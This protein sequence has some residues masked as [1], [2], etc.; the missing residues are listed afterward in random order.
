MT[1]E[2]SAW[3]TVENVDCIPSPALLIYPDRVEENIRRMIRIAGGVNRLRPHV[4]THKLA[5]IVRMQMSHGIT[6]FKCATIAEMEMVASCGAADVLLAFQP[7]G[8]N[9]RR[10]LQLSQVFPETNLC[11]VVDDAEAIRQLSETFCLAGKTIEVLLDIDCGMHRTGVLPG[12]TA[13][14][15]YRLIDSSIGLKAGGLHVYDGHLHQSDP[16]ERKSACDVAYAPVQDLRRQLEASGLSVPRIVAGGTPTF[17]I[18]ARRTEAECSPGTCVL[19]DFGYA[20]KLPD[21]DFLP[22]ALLL[23]RVIS[24]PGANFL[25]LDLGHKA[26]ASENPHPRVQFIEMPVAKA[27]VHSEEHLVVETP[28]ASKFSV[29][30]ALF[31]V[32]R[33]I[34]PTVAL[35]SEAVVVKRGRAEERWKISARNRTLTI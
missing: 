22:S 2:A 7:V 31:G 8:P 24:K 30:A 23:T 34:C 10:L 3:H 1:Q 35:H 32:P 6:K 28:L 4:K 20:N 5:E 12:S 27:I 9:V 25:C 16:E 13:I 21:L 33:H 26:V 15:L 11:A 14:D 18:H 19:S 17:P 29:G